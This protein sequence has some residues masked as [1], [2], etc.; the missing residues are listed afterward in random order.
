[1]S[2]RLIICVVLLGLFRGIDEGMT[3]IQA[4]DALYVGPLIG[5][6]GHEWFSWYHAISLMPY[7]ILAYAVWHLKKDWP[8][9]V[10]VLGLLLLIWQCTEMGENIARYGVPVIRHE[11]VNFAEVVRFNVDGIR[12]YLLHG[13]RT[14]MAIM[15]LLLGGRK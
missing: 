7:L 5:I 15:L 14:V 8:R 4:H 2:W 12:V 11:H 6:R 9:W 1:M 3:M 13:V 10:T